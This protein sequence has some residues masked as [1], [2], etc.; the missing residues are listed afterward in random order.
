[1]NVVFVVSNTFVDRHL[2]LRCLCHHSSDVAIWRATNSS[3]VNVIHLGAACSI[4]LLVATDLAIFVHCGRIRYL[5]DVLADRHQVLRDRSTRLLV[6]S[7]LHWNLFSVRREFPWG[8]RGRRCLRLCCCR[9]WSSWLM[10][11]SVVTFCRW[12]LSVVALRWFGRSGDA[13]VAF[14]ILNKKAYK[15]CD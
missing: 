14:A 6:L 5:E 9:Q 12:L 4:F 15:L 3:V 1:M 7:P 2:L 11:D 8:F 10:T 13:F